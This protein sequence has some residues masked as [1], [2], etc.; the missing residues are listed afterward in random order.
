MK[1]IKR[2]FWHSN[3][4]SSGG[5]FY[6]LDLISKYKNE[7]IYIVNKKYKT[8]DFWN[9]FQNNNNKLLDFYKDIEQ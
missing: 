4:I 9:T 1:I 6:N 7:Y 5:Y 2:V 8:I 3:N